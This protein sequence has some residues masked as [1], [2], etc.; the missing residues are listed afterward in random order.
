MSELITTD[1]KLGIAPRRN[2]RIE[3]EFKSCPQYDIPSMHPAPGAVSTSLPH[4]FVFGELCFLES[5]YV[6]LEITLPFAFPIQSSH[7]GAEVSK[8]FL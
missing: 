1:L 8:L 5:S 3:G 7:S 4:Q 6:G 2:F